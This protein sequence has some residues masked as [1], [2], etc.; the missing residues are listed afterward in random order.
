MN[1][2]ID[3]PKLVDIQIKM[4]KMEPVPSPTPKKKMKVKK[5][6][7]DE[8]KQKRSKAGKASGIRRKKDKVK[9]EFLKESMEYFESK[10][11]D[12]SKEDYTAI[13]RITEGQQF[14]SKT[15]AS[16]LLISDTKQDPTQIA[17]ISVGD[18][19]PYYTE[20][21]EEGDYNVINEDRIVKDTA[22]ARQARNSRDELNVK[23]RGITLK[24]YFSKRSSGNL[25]F[26]LE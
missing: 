26:I 4:D 15:P 5:P 9:R 10:Y 8:L 24:E 21:T 11:R 13:F 25:G 19:R 23:E 2:V 20:P 17:H 14:D 16:D 18:N 22:V 3:E 12:A 6:I 7:S 1:S